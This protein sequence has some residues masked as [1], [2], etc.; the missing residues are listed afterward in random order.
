[1]RRAAIVL[2]VSAC[3]Y[4]ASTLTSTPP[5]PLTDAETMAT[6]LFSLREKFFTLRTTKEEATK[7]AE[8]AE[9]KVKALEAEL[10]A[11]QAGASASAETEKRATDAEASAKALE[12]ELF[13]IKQE[14]DVLKDKVGCT[15]ESRLTA[16]RC[17][18]EGARRSCRGGQEGAPRGRGCA[19][20]G[21][22]GA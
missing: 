4:C 11:T 21:G 17:A 8:D 22:R 14:L 19:Q 1:M 9:D 6:D 15:K 12:G 7:R 20:R 18:R 16:G 5:P 10:A 13:A 3:A 2:A